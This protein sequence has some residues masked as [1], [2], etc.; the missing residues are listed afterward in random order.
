MREA[1]FALQALTWLWGLT[2]SQR[3]L[4]YQALARSRWSEARAWLST[5]TLYDPRSAG[6]ETTRH[7]IY[8]IAAPARVVKIC[9][10]LWR[11]GQLTRQQCT[12]LEDTL[13]QQVTAT[14]EWN[15]LRP[16]EPGR[17]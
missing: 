11:E 16:I 9:E 1:P 17:S 15:S 4:L 3:E 12:D 10:N 13:L 2:R 14:G 5:L 8:E 7:I 6:G